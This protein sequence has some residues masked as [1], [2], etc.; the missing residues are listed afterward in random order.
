M[1]A[2]YDNVDLAF[3]KTKKPPQDSLTIYASAASPATTD[4]QKVAPSEFAQQYYYGSFVR[5]K[6]RIALSA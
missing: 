4:G 3:T 1:Y 2:G 5:N 6:K